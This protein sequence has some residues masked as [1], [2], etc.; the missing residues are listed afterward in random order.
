MVDIGKVA[1]LVLLMIDGSFGLEMVLYI[2]TIPSSTYADIC[3]SFQETFEALSAMSSHGLPKLIAVLT[4][5]DLIK[6]QSALRAQKKRLKN[7]FWTEVYDGAKMFYLSGVINGRYPDREIL[8]LSRFISVAKFRPLIFRNSHS[9][10]LADRLE[11]LTPREEVRQNPKADRTVALWGYL[12]GIPMRAPSQASSLRIHIPGSGVDAFSVA[13]LAQLA[14]PCPLPTADS[15][16][17][18]KLNDKNRLVH[19]PFSGGAAGLLGG[20]NGAVTFDGDRVWVNTAG[21]FTRKPGEDAGEFA[22]E[23]EKMVMDLQEADFTLGDGMSTSQLKLF[24]DDKA[25]LAL[26]E[27][28]SSTGGR[29]RRLAFGE[30]ELRENADG[31]DDAEGSG[32]EEEE[33]SEFDYDEDDDDQAGPAI[34]DVDQDDAINGQDVNFDDASDSD[35]DDLDNEG[36]ILGFEQND[37]GLDIDDREGPNLLGEYDPEGDEEEEEGQGPQWKQDLS[38]KARQNFLDAQ[39]NQR[40]N[41]MKMIYSSDMTPREIYLKQIGGADKDSI[42]SAVDGDGDDDLFKLANQGPKE[43]EEDEDEDRFKPGK[44]VVPLDWQDESVVESFRKFFISGNLDDGDDAQ[45]DGEP[46]FEDLEKDGESDEDD[47]EDGEEA[48][49]KKSKSKPTSEE[50]LAAKKERLKRRFDAEY[51]DSSDE[52]GKMDFYTEQKEE[53]RKRL[54]ATQAEFANDDP[55]TRALVEGLRPGS[56]VR[57]EFSGVPAELLENFNSRFPLIVGAL[58][59]HEENFG[60]VQVRAKKHRWHPKI[61]KTNDPLIFSIGWR[62]FQT[63]PIYSLDDGTRNRMLKYTPEHMH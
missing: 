23:G 11:D 36:E 24:A 31:D 8:N 58:L 33:G 27:Q 16:K 49:V 50:A 22:G 14:D 55:E 40:P 15:E 62:R 57:L 63:V 47:G 12:R 21:N 18:R 59:P 38:M 13:R 43:G 5:L 35:L 48:P 30:D 4:H 45:A 28:G 53:M 44:K 1:D 46:A 52:E 9:Y 7:R 42:D 26:P 3:V 29:R 39:A 60:F 32:D 54:E 56:Y 19:A 61:L 2:I 20:A 6:S 34:N 25:P 41:L 10:M 37:K 51:D 17:R